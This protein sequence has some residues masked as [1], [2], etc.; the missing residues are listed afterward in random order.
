MAQ[1]LHA[2]VSFVPLST[3][4]VNLPFKWSQFLSEQNQL[5]QNVILELSWHDAKIA[6]GKAYVGWSGFSSKADHSDAIEI[7]PQFG[8]AIG[9]H[10]GQK[11]YFK[12]FEDIVP[13]ANSVEVEPISSDDWEIIERN[14]RYLEDSFIKQQRVVYPNE[15][16]G[17]CVKLSESTEIAVAPKSR[18]TKN[19][20][21]T[22]D[23]ASNSIFNA[24]VYCLRVLP[25][26][27]LSPDLLQP[28]ANDFCTVY[29]HPT[30]FTRIGLPNPKIVRVSKIQ[31]SHQNKE[32]DDKS[33]NDGRNHS[34]PAL[35]VKV[36]VKDSVVPG[37]VVLCESIMD[38]L[39]VQKFDIIRLVPPHSN[40]TLLTHI[41][42]RCIS[43]PFQS[44]SLKLHSNTSSTPVDRSIISTITNSVNA[45]IEKLS[46][47]SDIV[48]T[49]GM[50]LSLSS[51]NSDINVV[52]F[53]GG[54]PVGQNDGRHSKN[55]TSE[56]YA[57]TS[58]NHLNNIKIEVGD[59]ISFADHKLLKQHNNGYLPLLAGVE[60]LSQRLQK[61]LRY[62]LGKANLRNV[63][64]IPGMGGLLL[65]GGHGSGKTCIA[66]TV[67]SYLERDL[68]TLAYCS[69]IKCTELS[70][71]RISSV[72]EKLQT[73]FDDA[74]WHAP[75][76]LLFDDLDR[77]IPA[78]VEHV[79]SFRFR[80]LA[81]CFFHIAS[82]MLKRHR[83]TILATAQQKSSIHSFLTTSHLFSEIAQ[84]NPPTKTERYEILKAIMSCGPELAKKSLSNVD[85]LSVASE[86]EGYLAADL[87]TL[88]ERTIHEGAVRN[89]QNNINEADF[90]LVQDDF[91]KAQKGFVPFSLRGVK[92]HTSDVSWTDIGGLEETRK[93]LLETLEWPT[94]YAS[95]FANCPLRLRS[96]LLLYGFPGCGKTL[97]ASAVAK[98]C[99]LNFIS[100]KG[101]E[102]LNKY[103][104]ASEK[105]VRDLFE[106]AQA[107]KPCAL[108]FDEFDSIAPK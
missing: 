34:L 24:R 56:M 26:A 4:F 102:L 3:C 92:L 105:S 16:M 98:E 82:K 1:Q 44:A 97:L 66:K 77:L 89:L 21:E 86:C 84:L 81:E 14:S 35:Y 49:N 68:N 37:H 63:L 53:F 103:I 25:Q 67:A 87:K 75:S 80:Q 27:F 43:H 79:D 71:D 74:A 101:P 12:R 62:C 76:I 99:G 95:I 61:Y 91:R 78:E 38:V 107:A 100:V 2:I 72:R 58:K 94:K 93:V 69:V 32:T 46:A 22:K 55:D 33:D 45:W 40:S 17:P 106:R 10:H 88:V 51:A 70:E 83:I 48:L 5:P 42:I 13:E 29:I 28:S 85:L 18:K 23:I 50:K 9:L 47:S 36:L 108:F 96:G 30:D 90:L 54:K 73:F 20:A 52:A 65:C 11:I 41:I 19:N 64:H 104:G 7:D 31:P 59:N 8:E 39:D 15:V 6:Q 57:I 60:K